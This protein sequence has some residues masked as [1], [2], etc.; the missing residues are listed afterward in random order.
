MKYKHG[1]EREFDG[2]KMRRVVALAALEFAK[3]RFGTVQP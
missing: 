3:V 2:V 1:E